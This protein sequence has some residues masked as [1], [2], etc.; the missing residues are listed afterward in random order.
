[1]QVELPQRVVGDSHPERSHT[2][3][4]AQSKPTE[5]SRRSKFLFQYLSA[6]EFAQ[7]QVTK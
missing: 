1:M 7:L 6:A 4:V 3:F 2:E 5:K